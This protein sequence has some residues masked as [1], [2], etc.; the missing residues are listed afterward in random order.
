M[1]TDRSRLP[2]SEADL[3]ALPVWARVAFATRCA[4]YVQPLFNESLP[5]LRE[6]HVR[7]IEDAIRVAENVSFQ[8]SADHSTVA[9]AFDALAAVVRA[10]RAAR[11]FRAIFEILGA[12]TDS[13]AVAAFDA[14]EAAEHINARVQLLAALWEDFDFICAAARRYNWTDDTTIPLGYFGRLWPNGQPSG[15]PEQQTSAIIPNVAEAVDFLSAM[16]GDIDKATAE[17]R[18]RFDE[19]LRGLEGKNF[20]SLEA[21]QRTASLI[22]EVANRLHMTFTCSKCWKAAR[23]KVSSDRNCA[24]G[25]FRFG[26]TKGTHG[27][28]T[29]LPAL[30]PYAKPT[31]LSE[32]EI[33]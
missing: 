1:P 4:R 13:V 3:N 33:P 8:R 20:G 19:Y 7:A 6:E 26:H 32:A 12:R 11:A 10:V 27:A 14:L 28:T 24:T 22:Q 21:N 15:W 30:K 17:L 18:V 2:P 31:S 9:A 25:V 16:L 29:T 5:G 23:L